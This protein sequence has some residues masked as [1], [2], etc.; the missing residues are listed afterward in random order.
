M[1]IF[2]GVNIK[3]N[4]LLS[5]CLRCIRIKFIFTLIRC[6]M[7]SESIVF[8]CRDIDYLRGETIIVLLLPIGLRINWNWFCIVLK[9]HLRLKVLMNSISCC[10]YECWSSERHLFLLLKA[11]VI[12]LIVKFKSIL[13]LRLNCG[14]NYL[15]HLIIKAIIL[16]NSKIIRISNS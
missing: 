8:S 10:Y 14:L 3:S 1:L 7:E 16:L 15:I 4:R 5:I 2:G 6:L 13:I 12:H 11:I 9:L